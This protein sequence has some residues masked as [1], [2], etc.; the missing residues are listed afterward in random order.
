MR[1]RQSIRLWRES[2][3]A[4]FHNRRLCIIGISCHQQAVDQFRRDVHQQTDEAEC[5][6]AFWN[7]GFLNHSK[8]S[9]N[10]DPVQVSFRC[11]QL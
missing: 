10:T 3:H 4:T 6:D 11:W 8:R 5:P 9:D 7:G 2:Q 1:H